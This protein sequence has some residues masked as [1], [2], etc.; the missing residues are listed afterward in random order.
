MFSAYFL[1]VY[2]TPAFPQLPC[3]SLSCV[4]V[5]SSA[6]N[7][8]KKELVSWKEHDDE[9][10]RHIIYVFS[11]MKHYY[12]LGNQAFVLVPLSK[13][14]LLRNSL[15]ISRP[16]NACCFLCQDLEQTHQGTKSHL[17][18]HLNLVPTQLPCYIMS[19]TSLGS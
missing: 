10:H 2:L 11:R 8:E 16:D 7:L 4:S 13:K 19:T 9:L 12:F 14:K 1:L 5:W 17:L 15:H 6:R 3:M 18:T